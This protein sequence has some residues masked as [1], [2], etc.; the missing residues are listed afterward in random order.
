MS[1]LQGIFPTQVSHRSPALQADSLQAESQGKPKNAEV[2]F[3]GRQGPAHLR[4]GGENV[5]LV[6]DREGL[7]AKVRHATKQP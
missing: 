4:R 3:L 6:D 5:E 7:E 2:G 1:L